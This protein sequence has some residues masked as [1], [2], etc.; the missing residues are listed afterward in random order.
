MYAGRVEAV[1]PDYSKSVTYVQVSFSGAGGLSGCP[2]INREGRVI[3]LIVESVF[4][5]T[6]PGVPNREFLTVLPIGFALTI[7]PNGAR[8]QLPLPEK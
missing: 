2:V 3:G 8:V 7:S 4:E 5:Q 1:S 6:H